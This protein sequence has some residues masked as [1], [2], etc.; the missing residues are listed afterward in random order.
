M[1]SQNLKRLRE[2]HHM[3]QE[4]VSKLLHIERSTYTY[5]ETG[6][7]PSVETMIKLSRIYNITLDEMVFAVPTDGS[8]ALHLA[9]AEGEEEVAIMYVAPD[10]RRIVYLYRLC[11]DKQKATESLRQI[12]LENSV[13]D[14]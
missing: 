6:R 5:Y 1:V 12:G 10:E 11:E 2:A 3:T 7:M 4:Q 14:L 9:S 13:L 8:S